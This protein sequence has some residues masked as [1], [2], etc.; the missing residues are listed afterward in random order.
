MPCVASATHEMLI[1]RMLR[2]ATWLPWS[3][4]LVG[5][6]ITFWFLP[7]PAHLDE[8][9]ASLVAAI[10]WGIVVAIGVVRIRHGPSIHHAVAQLLKLTSFGLVGLS[11]VVALI[12]ALPGAMQL[13][14]SLFEQTALAPLGAAIGLGV[15]VWL[16]DIH[17]PSAPPRPP[18]RSRSP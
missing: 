17:N 14:P 7:P 15:G 4:A 13:R 12:A 9:F 10:D 8:S 5:W 16:G 1:V 2:H 6:L 3:L 11:A 18:N